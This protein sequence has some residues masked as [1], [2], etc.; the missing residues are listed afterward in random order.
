MRVSKLISIAFAVS[1]LLPSLAQAQTVCQSPCTLKPGQPYSLAFDWNGLDNSTPP[2]PVT[3]TGFQ[4]YVNNAKS[5]SPILA[6]QLVNGTV[7]LALSTPAVEGPY[8]LQFTVLNAGT[9]PTTT[10]A[11]SGKSVA[12]V[13][14]SKLA[15]P[16]APT[17]VRIIVAASFVDGHVRFDYMGMDSGPGTPVIPVQVGQ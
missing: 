12:V 3:A 16:S 17:N 14:N 13:L 5:G 2:Q 6:S 15:I 4:F 7:T 10:T 1:L 8:T 11:E 9:P